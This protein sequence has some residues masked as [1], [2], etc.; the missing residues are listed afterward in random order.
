MTKEGCAWHC[1]FDVG[2][3][4]RTDYIDKP[5][6]SSESHVDVQPPITPGQ[7]PESDDSM[8]NSDS[9]NSELP[10]DTLYAHEEESEPNICF[11]KR[12]KK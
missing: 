10:Q 5:F 1:S 3:F 2:V 6:D 12:R 8:S 11:A 9:N 7:E 4:N